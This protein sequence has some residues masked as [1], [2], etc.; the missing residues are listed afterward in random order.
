MSSYRRSRL[1]RR[2]HLPARGVSM[3]TRTSATTGAPTW[4]D[5]ATGDVARARSFYCD[6]FGWTADE[7]DE[8]YGGYFM[9]HRD[10]VPI[11][12][13]MG[14][15]E[16]GMPDTWSVYLASD[17]IEKTLATAVAEGGTVVV[18]AMVVGDGGSMAYLIDPSG[19]GIGV[20]QP[21]EF[22]GLTT[23]AE[24]GA[25]GWWALL[26]EDYSAALSF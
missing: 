17:D 19:A 25:P 8:Q 26:A 16:A 5:L 6:L 20:W 9:F 3:P 7:P 23:Y 14:K 1:H 4:V 24:T 12:G 10:G 21:K 15:Q 18:P 11:A 22:I 13:G 2:L